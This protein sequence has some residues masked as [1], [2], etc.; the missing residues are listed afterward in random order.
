[1][2]GLP[3]YYVS[4]DKF[5]WS[6]RDREKGEYPNHARVAYIPASSLRSMDAAKRAAEAKVDELN[7][8][9]S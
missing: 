8:K 1:M 6:V 3:H 7:A 9:G 4:A 5:G 2:S